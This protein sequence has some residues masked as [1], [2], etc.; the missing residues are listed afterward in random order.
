VILWSSRK[1]EQ[2]L[3]KGQLDSWTKVK[4]LIVP[5]VIGALSGPFFLFRP[6]YGQKPPAINNLFSFVFAVIAAFIAYWGIKTCFKI[7]NNIDGKDFF[8]RLAVL[9]LP[10]LIRIISFYIPS[11]IILSAIIGNLKDR[12]PIMFQRAPIIYSAFGPIITYMMY[13]MLMNSLKRLGQLLERE[14]PEGS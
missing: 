10:I 1:L 3:A 7:N 8:E 2:A 4:Y 12:V 14:K 9:T 13:S 5:M 11:I 6:V